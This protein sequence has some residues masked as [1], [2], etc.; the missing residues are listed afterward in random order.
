MKRLVG[1]LILLTVWAMIDDVVPISSFQS[2][3]VP[4]AD[5]DEY[6][7]AERHEHLEKVGG[8]RQQPSVIVQPRVAG[9]LVGRVQE[10]IR[11]N[12]TGPGSPKPLYVFMSLQL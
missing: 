12:L 3:P 4:N 8:R 9:L 10:P 1:L 7:P 5:D 11:S 6:L 2:A